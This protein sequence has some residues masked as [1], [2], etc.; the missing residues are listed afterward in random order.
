MRSCSPLTIV[1]AYYSMP[2]C[3]V[4]VAPYMFKSVMGT[5]GI[6][7]IGGGADQ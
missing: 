3:K 6:V 7:Y 2:V 4:L 1:T 5:V